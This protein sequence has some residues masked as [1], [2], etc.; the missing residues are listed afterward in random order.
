MRCRAERL[1]RPDTRTQRCATLHPRCKHRRY[2]Q[3]N[4]RALACVDAG[5]CTA[6]MFCGSLFQLRTRPTP[7]MLHISG[8][9]HLA[10]PPCIQAQCVPV[11]RCYTADTVD[12][13][14]AAS[15][16]HNHTDHLVWFWRCCGI[17]RST[18]GC[19]F[20]CDCFH[21]DCASSSVVVA[22]LP[23]CNY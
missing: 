21:A 4:H 17:C 3:P 11:W 14:D 18:T 1:A 2:Q 15:L 10:S 9:P 16:H 19:V 20:V 8:A 13:W 23:L 7:H 22:L 6:Y 12:S 5:A